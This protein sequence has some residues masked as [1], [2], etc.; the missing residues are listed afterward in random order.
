MI[1]LITGVLIVSIWFSFVFQLVL[2]LRIKY[3]PPYLAIFKVVVLV[4]TVA[5]LWML[6]PESFSVEY[7][8]LL[9]VFGYLTELVIPIY[10]L[11]VMIKDENG[12]QIGYV[13]SL[14]LLA[15]KYIALLPVGVVFMYLWGV[16]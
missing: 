9:S 13:N 14:I 12:N 6:V 1:E 11:A 10:V 5:K 2:K 7:K 15:S 3:K 4:E 16:D 8:T